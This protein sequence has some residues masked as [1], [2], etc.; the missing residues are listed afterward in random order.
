[1]N[2][3]KCGKELLEGETCTCEEIKESP[4]VE[5]EVKDTEPSDLPE[6]NEDVTEN[7][8]PD[9]EAV[10]EI[11][12]E[13]PPVKKKSK[14][15]LIIACVVI[16]AVIIAVAVWCIIRCNKNKAPA[17]RLEAAVS[18][19]L[20][21]AGSGYTKA[22]EETFEIYKSG[23]FTLDE[24]MTLE[25]GDS[26]KALIS[27]A[28]GS[29]ASLDWLGNITFDINMA[30]SDSTKTLQSVSVKSNGEEILT[31]DI[32]SDLE[33]GDIVMRCPTLGEEWINPYADFE[34]ELGLAL[35]GSVLDVSS[36]MGM[37]PSG[38]D[39]EKVLTRAVQLIFDYVPG[40]ELSTQTVEVGGLSCTA[41]R[42]TIEFSEK[43]LADLL[44]G[45]LKGLIEDETVE[46]VIKD[47]LESTGLPKFYV[48]MLWKEIP[49]SI[50]SAVEAL[51]D[52]MTGEETSLIIEA[53]LGSGDELVGFCVKTPDSEIEVSL[54][55][56]QDGINFAEELSVVY[57][58][59]KVFG[60]DF[61]SGTFENGKINGSA[62]I[63][64]MGDKMLIL[65]YVD[66]AEDGSEG[67]LRLK[68]G[69]GLV[70]LAAEE[71]PEA[72]PYISDA[73]LE[74]T[75]KSYSEDNSEM[76][77]SFYVKEEL[78]AA[79]NINVSMKAGASVSVPD[80]ES[81]V[82]QSE[83]EDSVSFDTLKENLKNA[84]IPEELIEGLMSELEG[85]YEYEMPADEDF[86][87]LFAEEL[88]A[89]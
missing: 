34:D 43:Q 78:F 59:D 40:V 80:V 87:S 56:V 77:M 60:I 75:L 49:D 55:S 27:E 26:A 15:G 70:D 6:A 72:L 64:V 41:E 31:F 66:L 18:R 32:F 83:W 9:T 3:E 7:E 21:A 74:L 16:L 81:A 65:E 5:E 20:K 45:V 53:Y 68:S 46:K 89:A 28:S 58:G 19:S 69:K 84:G 76:R 71:Y 29:D 35:E 88:E 33:T 62:D 63:T 25:L 82:S 52:E 47:M 10:P 13:E 38:E 54:M 17:E 14:K 86:D 48:N 2:C 85:G 4:E 1:M 12:S 79:V 67:T 11:I 30:T 39:V 42:F 24:S 36:L 23:T 37:F 8:T 51:K 61:A 73:V 44:G 22:Y 57:E 50:D